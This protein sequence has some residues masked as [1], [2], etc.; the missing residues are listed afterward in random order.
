MGP[1]EKPSLHSAADLLGSGTW[2]GRCSCE[3]VAARPNGGQGRD[4]R[5][6]SGGLMNEQVGVT[7]SDGVVSANKIQ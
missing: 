1:A 7:D 5:E 2:R 6:G 4:Y 3:G